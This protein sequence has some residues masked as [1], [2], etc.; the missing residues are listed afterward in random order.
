M[1][2]TVGDRYR[3]VQIC[4]LYEDRLIVAFRDSFGPIL[5]FSKAVIFDGGYFD[6]QKAQSYDIADIRD[7]LFIDIYAKQKPKI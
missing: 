5:S 4:G 1:F 7:L 6:G 2:R 3:L